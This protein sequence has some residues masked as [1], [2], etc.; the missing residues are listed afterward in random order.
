MTASAL[1]ASLGV[2]LTA[3]SANFESGFARASRSVQQARGIIDAEA[4]KIARSWKDASSGA[5]NLT[6]VLRQSSYQVGDLAV[7]LA[8]GQSALTAFVQQGSQLAGAFGPAGAAIGA[9]G[10]VLGAVAHGFLS[11]ADEA[12]R[13][14]PAAES[15]IATFHDLA[16][17]AEEA[18]KKIAG[19]SDVQKKFTADA[20]ASDAASARK[21][22]GG[23]VAPIIA[24]LDAKLRQ[25]QYGALHNVL[26]GQGAQRLQGA[27]GAVADQTDAAKGRLES[28]ASAGDIDGVSQALIALGIPGSPEATALLDITKRIAA[29]NATHQAAAALPSLPSPIAALEDPGTTG[30]FA[31]LP[32]SEDITAQVRATEQAAAAQLQADRQAAE[33]VA[34]ERERLARELAQRVAAVTREAATPQDVYNQKVKEAD[35]LLKRGAISAETYAKAIAKAKDELTKASRPDDTK[36]DQLIRDQE[37]RWRGD[38]D[39]ANARRQATEEAL[40]EEARRAKE[41]DPAGLYRRTGDVELAPVYDAKTGVT[42]ALREMQD[43]SEQFGKLFGDA[44]RGGAE[45]ATDAISSFVLQGKLDVK[46]LAQSIEADLVHSAVRQLVNSLVG[47]GGTALAGYFGGGA[48]ATAGYTTTSPWAGSYGPAPVANARGGVYDGPGI[49]AYSSSIVDRPTLF[50][51]AR[52]TGLMGDAAPKASCRCAAPRAATW[53]C[54]WPDRRQCQAVVAW[55]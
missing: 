41:Q 12:K 20:A 26:P 36:L 34:R 47:A 13:L 21:E 44:V 17:A 10:A 54:R 46:S 16:A 7:Q 28:A 50:P 55:W 23:A 27:L 52:G 45:V 37:A 29:A 30:A 49:S 9:V 2:S 19:L 6:E 14:P 4:A 25:A 38:L 35:D 43:Q 42:D 51:F 48:G 40:A 8:S 15:A 32:T 53:A 18:Q 33:K 11:A 22:I 31:L 24:G 5:L 1:T 3:D 39:Q